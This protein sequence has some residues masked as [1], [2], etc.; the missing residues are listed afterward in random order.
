MLSPHL[1]SMSNCQLF[2]LGE[3]YFRMAEAKR[4]SEVKLN[5]NNKF[6][7]LSLSAICSLDGTTCSYVS[8]LSFFLP[9]YILKFALKSL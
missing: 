1:L 8:E 9:F 3:L 2:F 7:S 4:N 6:N 5:E